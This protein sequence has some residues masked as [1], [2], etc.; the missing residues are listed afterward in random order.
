MQLSGAVEYIYLDTKD[1]TADVLSK[2]L[3]GHFFD[4]HITKMMG[5]KWESR[6]R[7]PV[8]KRGISPTRGAVAKRPK[9]NR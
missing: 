4:K 6:F 7:G 8:S 1:M 3:H 9:G 2:A 5:L